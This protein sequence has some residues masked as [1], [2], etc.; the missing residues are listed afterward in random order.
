LSQLVSDPFS[1]SLFCLFGAA[2]G[3]F[4]FLCTLAFVYPRLR[5]GLLVA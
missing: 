2:A 3:I 4:S 1:S 5:F